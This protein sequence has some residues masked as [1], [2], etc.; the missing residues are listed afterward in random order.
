MRS[1]A[2]RGR[3]GRST[4]APAAMAAVSATTT[5]NDT[6]SEDSCAIPPMTPGA[7][8]RCR[9]RCR[10]PR[11]C[12]G[13]GWRRC[14]RPRRTPAAPP[15]RC[16]CRCSA[17]PPTTRTTGASTTVER[18]G[19][20]AQARE[21]D[22]RRGP[23]PA[24]HPVPGEPGHRHADREHGHGQRRVLAGWPEHVADVH[25]GPVHPGAFGEHR[26]QPDQADRHH[27]PRGQRER[28][29]RVHLR[30]RPVRQQPAAGRHRHRG[31]HDRGDEELNLRVRCQPARE[32]RRPRPAR[33]PA[34][35]HPCIPDITD[36]P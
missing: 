23:D 16:R 32:A 14:G 9:R 29:R 8:S 15:R 10:R 20:G 27:G 28:R 30:F 5:T 13:P 36:R 17:N 3:E 4:P 1:E 22:R 26:A 19:G 24:H 31:Q 12:C 2:G 35:Q 11:R 7:I 33:P 6:V 25:R 18:P 34:L 21:P